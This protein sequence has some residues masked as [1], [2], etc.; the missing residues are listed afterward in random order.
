MLFSI[1]ISHTTIKANNITKLV[2]EYISLKAKLSL[3]AMKGK[4]IDLNKLSENDKSNYTEEFQ[5]IELE[6]YGLY[7]K[8]DLDK[9]FPNAIWWENFF[10]KG[11]IDSVELDKLVLSKYFPEDENIPSWRR[12]Y[13]FEK[14][15][16]QDFETLLKKVESECNEKKFVDIEEVKHV[17]GVL[18]SLSHEGLYDKTQEDIFQS[19]KAYIDDL[20]SNG[21]IPPLPPSI[22]YDKFNIKFNNNYDNLMFARVDLSEFK[23]I[24]AYI[25]HIQELVRIKNLPDDAQ[26]LLDTMKNNPSKFSEMVYLNDQIESKYCTVPIFK[27]VDIDSFINIL[28]SINY[29]NQKLIFIALKERY[30]VINDNK[31]LI[32]EI[33]WLKKLQELIKK[34]FESKK[35]KPT[36]YRLAKLNEDYLNKTIKDLELN[37]N[38]YI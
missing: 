32:D 25:E 10:D 4:T 23:K 30:K 15:S 29:E 16:D 34:E 38:N 21:K 17:F 19:A 12:L 9:V 6:N 2:Q 36:R 14:L 35:D 11:I 27:Y 37:Q 8:F 26:N 3:E 20:H 13:Y 33:E 22:G 24:I 1:G 31:E 18:L 7:S 28:L 5:N